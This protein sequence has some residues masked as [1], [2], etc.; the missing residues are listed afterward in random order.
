MPFG[1]HAG[2]LLR[3][4]PTRYVKWLKAQ[5]WV[6]DPLRSALHRESAMRPLREVEIEMLEQWWRQE[7][8]SR[9]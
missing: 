1:K 9:E 7:W 5:P 4:L 6:R 8:S 3:D 2:T